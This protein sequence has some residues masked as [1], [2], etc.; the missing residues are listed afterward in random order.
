MEF[1]L[2]SVSVPTAHLA[3]DA[4]LALSENVPGRQDV[5]GRQERR[6]RGNTCRP[7]AAGHV[8]RQGQPGGVPGIF[9]ISDRFEKFIRGEVFLLL[10]IEAETERAILNDEKC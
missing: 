7:C 4:W 1:F 5:P 9:D 3:H 6:Q 2:D 10:P 8:L